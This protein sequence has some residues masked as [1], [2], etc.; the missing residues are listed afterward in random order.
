MIWILAVLLMA[1]CAQADV[2]RKHHIASEFIGASEGT[3][4][5]YYAAD[6]H[7][8]QST[9]RFTRGV[10]KTMSGGKERQS[11]DITRL[12]KELMW[13]VDPK[14]KSYT[15]MTFA[16]F[17]D[18]L[19]K[20]EQQLK[21]AQ[22]DM[23]ADT[24]KEDMYTW[25]VEDK[26]EK[27]AKTIAGF[28]C[29]NAQIVA[30]GT[31]KYDSLDKVIITVNTWNC[32]DV[33]GAADIQAFNERY[34]KALGLDSKILTPGLMQ[35][36]MNYQK[37]FDALIEAAKKAPGEPVQSLMEVQR[38]EIKR[39]SVGDAMKEGAKDELMSKLPFGKK[40]SPPKEQKIEYETTVK[41]RVQT[42][43]IEASSGAA[44]PSVYEVPAGFKLKKK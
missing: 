36:A 39:P 27:D 34:V 2:T 21:D 32:P 11:G 25:Q 44:D 28:S 7:A 3:T 12:D 24:V 6:R 22:R 29:R 19:K 33:P 41:F 30:T 17:R 13:N 9:L 16:E 26:S 8:Q 15:E 20:N 37:Q 10:M 38:N 1:T 14:D 23:P 42:D 31:S 35:A 4:T 18:M 43:L 5:D 40:K